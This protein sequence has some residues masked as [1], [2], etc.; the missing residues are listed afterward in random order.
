MN[1]EVETHWTYLIKRILE[2]LEKL[3]IEYK[4]KRDQCLALA[5]DINMAIENLK[6]TEENVN[7]EI[8]ELNLDP[9]HGE[10]TKIRGL[11][12]QYKTA[13][14]RIRGEDSRGAN[15]LRKEIE[16]VEKVIKYVQ[17]I[18]NFIARYKTTTL[19]SEN[20]KHLRGLLD[21]VLQLQNRDT[22]IDGWLN[23]LNS[24]QETY[25]KHMVEINKILDAF[26][27]KS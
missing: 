13:V 15:Q 21:K 6:E 9:N 7:K 24:E 18:V 19:T 11:L 20:I 4:Q 25:Y 12:E 3:L 26:K 10:V 27:N 17:E 8:T 2:E 22:Y 23:R 5:R 16:D 1:R 14:D